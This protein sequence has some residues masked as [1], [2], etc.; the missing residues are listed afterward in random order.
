MDRYTLPDPTLGRYDHGLVELR[1]DDEVRAYLGCRVM[2]R[3]LKGN[4]APSPWF[5]VVWPD[6]TKEMS[7][8]D[9][10]PE[11]WT[12]RELDAGHFVR[13]SA[14]PVQRSVRVLGLTLWTLTEQSGD[15]IEYEVR[16]LPSVAAR[17]RE[18][19]L[20]LTDNDF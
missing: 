7:F 9:Y 1:V 8:E 3:G 16:W 13:G 19:E 5:V 10:G 4:G 14:P 20:G 2:R 6:G 12:I 15:D 18:Q 11:W 17:Q